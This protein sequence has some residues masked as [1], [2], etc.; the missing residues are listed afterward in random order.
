M[1]GRSLA[2]QGTAPT[3]YPPTAWRMRRVKGLFHRPQRPLPVLPELGRQI[4][5]SWRLIFPGPGGLAE[6]WPSRSRGPHKTSRSQPLGVRGPFPARSLPGQGAFLSHSH[7]DT[8]DLSP[9]HPKEQ[10]WTVGG[11]LRGMRANVHARHLP[12]LRRGC[13]GPKDWGTPFPLYLLAPLISPA[14]LA[15]APVPLTQLWNAE[16]N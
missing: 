13:W 10:T 12:D 8:P 5:G 9:Y 2:P 15:C 7:L 1:R 11:L 14:P 6:S 16:P 4:A 3:P